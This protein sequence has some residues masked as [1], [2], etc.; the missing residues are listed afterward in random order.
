MTARISTF[1]RS[2]KFNSPNQ[3]PALPHS[4]IDTPRPAPLQFVPL[5]NPP[6]AH[7]TAR[8]VQGAQRNPRNRS[9]AQGS[10]PATTGNDTP[11]NLFDKGETLEHSHSARK[12]KSRK[13]FTPTLPASPYPRASPSSASR[14][15]PIDG[16]FH[17]IHFLKSN[18]NRSSW[19]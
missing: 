2:A 6:H 5:A 8:T 9:L 12:P 14:R 3:S 15:T 11:H 4:A 10:Y 13:F 16:R 7:R 17:E 19:K 18:Q 1:K